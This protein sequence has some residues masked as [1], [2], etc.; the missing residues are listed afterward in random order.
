MHSSRFAGCIGVL[1]LMLVPLA[2]ARRSSRLL[3]MVGLFAAAYVVLWASPPSSQQLRFLIPVVPALAVVAAHGLEAARGLAAGLHP[4][5]SGVPAVVV[6]AT[7]ALSI[8]AFTAMH[9]RD[10]ELTLTHVLRGA[11]ADV[12]TGAESE[13]RYLTRKLP[14]YG[15]AQRLRKGGRVVALTDPYVNFYAAPA[16]I[17]DWSACITLAGARAGD[18]RSELRALRRLGAN[19]LLVE[20]G[21]RTEQGALAVVRKP[22]P[23][24]TARV[25]YRDGRAVVYR[26][27]PAR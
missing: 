6:V 19:R 1:F 25:V 14:A 9:D 23:A 16:L 26:L 8:P 20:P 3:A 2:F 17:P 11:P 5:A 18:S 12:V 21:I 22:P 4:R 27:L 13:A 10:G 24:G 15:A 7:L